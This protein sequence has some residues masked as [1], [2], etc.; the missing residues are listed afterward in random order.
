MLTSV[1]IIEELLVKS[2]SNVLSVP[3]LLSCRVPVDEL[4]C[5]L[6][7]CMSNSVSS[8]ESMEPGSSPCIL[9]LPQRTC[10]SPT[11]MPT[12]VSNSVSY[13]KKVGFDPEGGW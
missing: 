4:T 7:P 11:S 10:R 13:D 1:M 8:L 5:C 2:I 3:V 9:K 12:D 6:Y